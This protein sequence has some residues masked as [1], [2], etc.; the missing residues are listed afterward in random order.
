[1]YDLRSGLE[2]GDYFLVDPESAQ[3]HGLR[4]ELRQL[5]TTLSSEVREAFSERYGR[6]DSDRLAAAIATRNCAELESIA[7]LA[8]NTDAGFQAALLLGYLY[9]DQRQPLEAVGW[10]QRLA[11]DP[12]VRGRYEPQVSVLL[13]LAWSQAGVPDLAHK[14]LLR[15]REHLPDARIRRGDQD[16]VLFA[17]EDPLAVIEGLTKSA[18]PVA[19]NASDWPMHR[20]NPQRNAIASQ[21]AM[22]AGVP[23]AGRIV[24][25]EPAMSIA[26]GEKAT[27]YGGRCHHF[28][29]CI[30]FS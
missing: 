18:N 4:R 14:C 13:A 28:L 15:L 26:S 16:F 22:C 6:M 20:G 9:L 5:G 11:E 12:A 23:E 29:L 2:A 27:M 10:L 7:R 1:M 30:P 25:A 24:L 8:A 19:E 3:S 17:A 21:D